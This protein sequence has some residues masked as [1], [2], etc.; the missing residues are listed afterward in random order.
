MESVKEIPQEVRE[1]VEKINEQNVQEYRLKNQYY[2]LLEQMIPMLDKIIVYFSTGNSLSEETVQVLMKSVQEINK[3]LE[4]CIF[5]KNILPKNYEDVVKQLEEWG[6]EIWQKKMYEILLEM[7][8]NM[9][10]A[11][12][13]A[14][15]ERFTC[16]S[17]QQKNFF[18]PFTKYYEYMQKYYGATPWR[19]ETQ[20]DEHMVCPVCGSF[21]RE[22]LIILALSK[23]ELQEKRVLQFAPSVALDN[24]LKN[25]EIGLYESCDLFMDGVSFQADIQN[26][27]MV[28]SQSY[29]I[30]ICSHVL[31]HVQDDKK[32]MKELFRITKKGGYGLVLVPLDLEQKETTEEWGR[33]PEECWRRFGQDD[34]TRKY[35]KQEFIE[36]LENVGFEVEQLGKIAIGEEEFRENALSDSSVLYKVKRK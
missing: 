34:H 5:R 7:K 16:C 9:V 18:L 6:N 28:S 31:E 11:M 15:Q 8:A 14:K 3:Y 30:W 1:K 10:L 19:Y 29:D 33:P 21:D 22:R 4:G 2:Q 24:Y 26:M 23:E 12:D 27:D 17:C 20:N 25:R 35:A 36:R 32:A 13:T